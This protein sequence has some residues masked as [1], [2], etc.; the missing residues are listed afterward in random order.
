MFIVAQEVRWHELTCRL[1]LGAHWDWAAIII[2][3][4]L[5]NHCLH[6][7]GLY[8]QNILTKWEMINYQKFYFFAILTI[9]SVTLGVRELNGTSQISLVTHDAKGEMRE[10]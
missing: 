4:I 7:S 3:N 2:K 8:I 9:N 1:S 10:I 5:C 6:D